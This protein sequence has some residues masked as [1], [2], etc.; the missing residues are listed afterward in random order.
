MLVCEGF[1]DYRIYQLARLMPMLLGAVPTPQTP[2]S[3]K[4]DVKDG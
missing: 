3:A 1:L 2:L 4:S